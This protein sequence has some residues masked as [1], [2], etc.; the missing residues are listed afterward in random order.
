VTVHSTERGTGV[1]L[2]ASPVRDEDKKKYWVYTV[3]YKNSDGSSFTEEI[4]ESAEDTAIT[5]FPGCFTSELPTEFPR[6]PFNEKFDEHFEEVKAS[7]AMMANS[8]V[9]NKEE[10]R[11]WE[12]F[13]GSICHDVHEIPNLAC[14]FFIPPEQKQLA[15]R[16][17][18]VIQLKVDDGVRD[19]DIVQ[20]AAFTAAD[21]RKKQKTIRTELAPERLEKLDRGMFLVVQL[22]PTWENY[23]HEFVIGEI[24]QNIADL[25]TTNPNQQF[26]VQV[27]CFSV[28]TNIGSKLFP[29]R[30]AGGGGLWKETI[31]RSMVKAIVQVQ[32]KGK[33]LTPASIRLIQSTNF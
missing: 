30:G 27:Y 21:R 15:S 24:Q 13:F 2:K 6:E 8:A 14:P 7:V 16:H 33:R 29:W 12:Q 10:Q 25:D 3:Q 26:E 11:E 20:H 19:V 4:K 17:G 9:I 5:V 1:V 28:L 23:P 32:P 22:K 31:T 18:H